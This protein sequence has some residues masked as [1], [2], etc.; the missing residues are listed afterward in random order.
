MFECVTIAYYVVA[1][2]WPIALRGR[3]G[4]SLSRSVGG[5]GTGGTKEGDPPS[6]SALKEILSAPRDCFRLFALLVMVLSRPEW[7]YLQL[8]RRIFF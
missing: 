5:S 1:L 7:P 3:K 2:H 4:W 6:L 8:S